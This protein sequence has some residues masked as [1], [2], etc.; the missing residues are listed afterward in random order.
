MPAMATRRG[1]LSPQTGLN[2][3]RMTAASTDSETAED[4][5]VW[6]GTKTLDNQL[7]VRIDNN[8]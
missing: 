6:K 8:W 3:V 5:E 7:R 1:N 2:P 4:P